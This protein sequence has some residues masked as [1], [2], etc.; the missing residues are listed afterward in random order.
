MPRS[1][2]KGTLS[3]GLVT[4]PVQ[5]F[6]ATENKIRRLDTDDPYDFYFPL[7]CDEFVAVI[8]HGLPRAA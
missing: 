1:L 5:L 7:D 2:W 3:F 8:E 4:I 6:S